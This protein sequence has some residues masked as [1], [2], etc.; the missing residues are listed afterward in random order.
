MS[1]I[2][3]VAIIT[4]SVTLAN[5]L[6]SR[7]WRKNDELVKLRS[8]IK[9]L[10]HQV[11]RIAKGMDIALKNDQVIF[12]AFR[13]NQIN[14]ESEVQDRIMEDYFRECAV[15]GFMAKGKEG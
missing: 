15:A 3:W 10:E 5:A 11:N 7:R 1:D 2:I 4:G 9:S 14:G 12:D 6:I 8:A 13:K